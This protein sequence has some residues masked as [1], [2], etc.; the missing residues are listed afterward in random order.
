MRRSFLLAAMACII[1]P[2]TVPAE[3]ATADLIIRYQRESSE[4]AKRDLTLKMIDVGVL[5]L[6]KTTARDLEKI[7]GADWTP[8]MKVDQY[9]SVGFVLFA[10]Q[11]KAPSPPPGADEPDVQVPFVGWY[12]LVHYNTKDRAV[13]A[14]EL[15][16]V[17]K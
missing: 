14:W 11:P 13:F 5:K 15:S 1:M 10:K 7:F 4:L 6:F 12:L 2:P 3:D 9:G 16:N 17:H 8:D